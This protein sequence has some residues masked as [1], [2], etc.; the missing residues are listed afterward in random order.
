[1]PYEDFEF[2]EPVSWLKCALLKHQIDVNSSKQLQARTTV[3]PELKNFLERYAT[4]ARNELHL[5]VASKAIHVLRKLPNTEE[6]DILQK[7]AKEN[8]KFWM[9]Y[10]QALTLRGRWLAETCNENSSVIMRDYLEK[11]LDVL[12]N[13]NGNNDKNYAS[14]VCNAF[15]AVARYAD[16]QYQSIINYEK[17]TAYQAKLESIKNSRDQANQLRIKDITDDQRKLHLILTRQ[18]DIDQTEV[19]SVEADKKDFLKKL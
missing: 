13:I 19:K 11:A 12:K 16:G 9:Y 3:I 6:E 8:P 14:S 5:E 17:S 15:L 10:G 18:A 1:M 7:F 2:V 4:S